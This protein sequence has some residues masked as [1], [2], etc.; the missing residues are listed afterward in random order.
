MIRRWFK[1]SNNIKLNNDNEEIE[2]Y[3]YLLEYI[4]NIVNSILKDTPHTCYGSI[5]YSDLTDCIY[6]DIHNINNFNIIKYYEA[7]KDNNIFSDFDFDNHFDY[8]ILKLLMSYFKLYDVMTLNTK[9]F[10]NKIDYLFDNDRK[11]ILKNFKNLRFKLKDTIANI[12]N[13]TI[14]DNFELFL[15]SAK[16]HILHK[17][18]TNENIRFCNI[19]IRAKWLTD[20]IREINKIYKIYIIYPLY[21][22]N[23][24]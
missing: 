21:N 11:N 3:N 24:K 2:V 4:N 9:L 8:K 7:F 1:K 19:K 16:N 12:I 6:E 22:I 23:L 13:K 18:I 15:N 17:I 10:N 14:N 20:T 5:I